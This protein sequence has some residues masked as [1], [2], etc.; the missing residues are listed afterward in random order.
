MGRSP[1][2]PHPSMGLPPRWNVGD[3]TPSYSTP[4]TLLTAITAGTTSAAINP[5]ANSIEVVPSFTD[6]TTSCTIEVLNDDGT[7]TFVSVKTFT[8]VTI[9]NASGLEV[10][11]W[12]TGISLKGRAIKV[13]VS[14]IVGPGAITVKIL[15]LN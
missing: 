9:F 12:P 2:S 4:A 11:E 1:L 5:Q 3:L 15:R 13:T 10:G 14:A 8:G 6:G 7:G